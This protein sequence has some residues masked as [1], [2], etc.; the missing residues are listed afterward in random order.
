[1]YECDVAIAGGVTAYPKE[2]FGYLYEENMIF[3]S[4]GHCRTFDAK[5]NGTIFGEGVGVVV[6]KRLEDAITENHHIYAVIKGSAINNDGNRKVG[7]T[8][9]SVVGQVEVIH[10]ALHRANVKPDSISYVEAH[11]TATIM[12][13]PIEIEALTQVFDSDKKK[14]CKIGSV[15]SNFGHLDAAAGVA[16]FIKTVLSLKHRMIPPSLHYET[17]NPAINL[18]DSPFEVN[19]QLITWE[20]NKFPRRAGVSSMGMGGTNA[21]VI[22]EEAP[23]KESSP[24]SRNWHIILLSAKSESSLNMAAKN[25]ADFL[26]KD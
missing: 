5:G 15:K 14:F 19:T 13:D 3:S 22:L 16:G 8:A 10:A 7:F 24:K 2:K 21:H 11:G 20:K 4:D 23:E 1:M 26:K 12:G 6:L 18:D 9:P 17:P 25:L